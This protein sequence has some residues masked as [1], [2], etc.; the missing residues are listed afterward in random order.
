[1]SV[2]EIVF[3]IFLR[4]ARTYLAASIQRALYRC[5]PPVKEYYR[6]IDGPVTRY[7]SAWVTSASD[8]WNVRCDPGV[9]SESRL[10][11]AWDGRFIRMIDGSRRHFRMHLTVVEPIIRERVK[12]ATNKRLSKLIGGRV[13]VYLGNGEIARPLN[14]GDVI[15]LARMPEPNETVLLW[16]DE[17]GIAN[18]APREWLQSE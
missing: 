16:G 3:D 1:M 7:R 9:E 6:D 13:L 5:F 15:A 18:G 2:D 4:Q 12:R 8:G 10:L 11:F 17:Y 14:P